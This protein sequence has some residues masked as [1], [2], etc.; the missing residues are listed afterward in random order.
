MSNNIVNFC[1]TM[2]VH[3]VSGDGSVEWSHDHFNILKISLLKQLASLGLVS[4]GAII[5]GV[6]PPMDLL[7][8]NLP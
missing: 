8:F 7:T 1:S 5:H 4:P 6:T 2:L 3:K